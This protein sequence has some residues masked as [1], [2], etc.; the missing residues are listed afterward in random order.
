MRTR[1]ACPASEHPGGAR[2]GEGDHE[3]PSRRGARRPGAGR[4]RHGTRRVRVSR[5]AFGEQD[6][7]DR[8]GSRRFRRATPGPRPGT[9][10]VPRARRQAN[11]PARAAACRKEQ[12]A[13]IA[14]RS[15][16]TSSGRRSPTGGA[17]RSSNADAPRTREN[18][19]ASSARSPRRRSAPWPKLQRGGR[20]SGWRA[21]RSRSS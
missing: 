18:A 21:S 8:L 3:N 17:V 6:R 16:T 10:G 1:L 14:T 20:S 15:S 13:T 2:G 4:L 19:S 7:V 12:A 11:R 9:A 5:D